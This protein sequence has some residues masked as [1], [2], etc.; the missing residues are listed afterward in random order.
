MGGLM[1][2]K[3]AAAKPA[4]IGRVMIVDALP[5]YSLLYGSTATAATATPFAE[6]ARTQILSLSDSDFAEGPAQPCLLNTSY[7]CQQQRMLSDQGLR[8]K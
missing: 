7:A 2:L 1:A 3:I 4:A 5:F 6:Q 8:E